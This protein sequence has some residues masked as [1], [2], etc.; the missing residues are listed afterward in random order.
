VD[1]FVTQMKQLAKKLLNYWCGK[2]E[3]HWRFWKEFDRAVEYIY[4]TI[5]DYKLLTWLVPCFLLKSQGV[6][7]MVRRGPRELFCV[8]DHT[9]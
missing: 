2:L 7:A 8:L 3:N 1:E 6:N 5:E 9:Y 4:D